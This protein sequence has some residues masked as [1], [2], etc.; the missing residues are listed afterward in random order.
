MVV[1]RV[2]PVGGHVCYLQCVDCRRLIAIVRYWLHKTLKVLLEVVE[3]RDDVIGIV[4]ILR[5]EPLPQEVNVPRIRL[6]R[7]L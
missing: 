7:H 2:L 5:V 6:D 3:E 4:T 1:L